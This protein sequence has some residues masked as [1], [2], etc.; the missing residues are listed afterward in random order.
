MYLWEEGEVSVRE[1]A[2]GEGGC[3]NVYV[4]LNLVNYLSC[5]SFV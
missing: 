2:Q 1:D 3:F 4:E 5:F